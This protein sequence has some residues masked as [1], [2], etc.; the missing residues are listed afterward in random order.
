V[1]FGAGASYGSQ[2]S[3]NPP[4]G[5][6]LF[7]ALAKFAPAVW[8]SLP[9]P[10]PNDFRTDFEAAMS[11]L[12][13]TSFFTAQLQWIMAEYFF[14]SFQVTSESLYIPFAHALKTKPSTKVST[15]NYDSLLFQGFSKA[16]LSASIGIAANPSNIST[17]LPHGSSILFLSG[18]RATQGMVT[19]ANRGVAFGGECSGAYNLPE[20]EK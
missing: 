2:T 14:R 11:K 8:G 3:S 13:D 20:P 16:G 5:A 7:E 9:Q 6:P 15:L 12:M 18:P 10:W 19:F 17:S 4:L 1:I